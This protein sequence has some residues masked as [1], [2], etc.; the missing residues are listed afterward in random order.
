MKQEIIEKIKC[1]LDLYNPQ[2]TVDM[3]LSS[4]ISASVRHNALYSPDVIDRIP[5]H[6]YWRSQLKS[7]GE[8]YFETPQTIETFRNDIILLQNN[9]NNEFPDSFK[10]KQY[11]NNPGFRISHAQKSLSVYLKHMWCIKVEQCFDNKSG[12][13][14]PEYPVCPM[15]RV[16]LTIVNCPDTRWGYVNTMEEYNKKLRYIIDAANME[17]ESLAIWEL[18]AF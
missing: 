2:R 14:I 16:I 12:V 10:S 11:V 1:F 13:D 15:D 4:G 18:M 6:C 8:K 7:F 5:I 17:H 3:A 9:M